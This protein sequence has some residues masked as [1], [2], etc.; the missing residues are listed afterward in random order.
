LATTE[1]VRIAIHVLDPRPDQLQQ[2]AHPVAALR[3]VAHAM[4]DAAAAG[5]RWRPRPGLQQ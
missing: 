3:F 1:G 2:V 5:A 4:D